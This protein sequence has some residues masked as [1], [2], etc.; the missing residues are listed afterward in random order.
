MTSSPLEVLIRE[1]THVHRVTL[2]LEC[3]CSRGFPPPL[4]RP[5]VHGIHGIGSRTFSFQLLNPAVRAIVFTNFTQPLCR[6]GFRRVRIF[7]NSLAALTESMYANVST[8]NVNIR[9]HVIDQ[10]TSN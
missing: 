6:A 4:N 5:R 2:F 3:V 8:E 1:I 9:D 10:L 7:C